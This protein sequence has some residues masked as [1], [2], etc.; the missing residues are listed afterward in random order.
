MD[1]QQAQE[2]I[3]STHTFPGT[4]IFKIVGYKRDSFVEKVLAATR[5]VIGGAIAIKHSTNETKS[6]KH[7]AITMEPFVDDSDQ[8]LAIYQKLRDVD[9]V[10]MFL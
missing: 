9:D 1:P 3:D 4:Y 8:V 10:I 5:E 2:L 7:I 6:G